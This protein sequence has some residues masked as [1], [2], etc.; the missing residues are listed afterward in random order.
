MSVDKTGKWWV[1]DQ[2]S[3]I[4]EFLEAYAPDGYKVGEFR[5]AKCMC[6]SD[7][8][9]CGPTTTKDVRGDNANRANSPISFATARNTGKTPNRNNG[10]A[11]YANQRQAHVTLALA[12]RY[13]RTA[14][15]GGFTSASGALSVASWVA[16]P[17]GRSLMPPHANC[18]SKH[19]WLCVTYISAL[20]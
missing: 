17:D 9:F 2:P 18:L 19:K 1:G 5:L 7:A 12:S 14:K 16:S 10:N 3:D 20:I 13:T 4:R 8:S 6:G 15:S 11:S